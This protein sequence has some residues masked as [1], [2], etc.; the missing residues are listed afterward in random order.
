MFVSGVWGPYY[1]AMIPG[2][3]L[4][5]GGQSAAG[6]LV[7]EREEGWRVRDGEGERELEERGMVSER[8][9]GGIYIGREEAYY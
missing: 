9:E 7:R 6:S 5:E 4:N 3:Y 8:W 2:Y 1:S